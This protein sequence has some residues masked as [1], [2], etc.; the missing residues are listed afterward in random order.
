MSL[1]VNEEY[2]V[3]YPDFGSSVAPLGLGFSVINFIFLPPLM[4]IWLESAY[5]LF[6]EQTASAQISSNSENLF[7]RIISVSSVSLIT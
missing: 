4:R 1:E 6:P 2:S 7:H 3:T 5:F